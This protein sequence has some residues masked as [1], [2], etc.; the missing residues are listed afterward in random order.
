MQLHMTA[1]PVYFPSLPLCGKGQLSPSTASLPPPS[2]LPSPGSAQT[3]PRRKRASAASGFLCTPSIKAQH[4][5][6]TC[7]HR[8]VKCAIKGS[9]AG[10]VKWLLTSA[11][12]SAQAAA[13]YRQQTFTVPRLFLRLIRRQSGGNSCVPDTISKQQES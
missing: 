11:A 3:L 7:G 13:G 1:S 9:S 4:S 12:G 8:T 10:G 5:L 2:R 6:G